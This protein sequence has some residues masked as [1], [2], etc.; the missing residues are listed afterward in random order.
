MLSI[1][2]KHFFSLTL[3]TV[4]LAGCAHRQT[5][6]Y[7][8]PSLSSINLIDRNGLTE[9][10]NSPERLE[11]YSLVNFLQPQPYQKVLR[12]YSRDAHGNIPAC[13][14]SYHV[15]GYPHKYLEVMNSRACGEYK[16]WFANGV[17]KIN[18]EVIEGSADIVNGAERSWVFD[19]N[20][21]AWDENGKLEAR[22]I[23]NKG[24]LEG[25]SLY[26]HPNGN[27]W[28]S[29]PYVQNKINGLVQIFESDET[30]LQ[31][32]L[33]QN[34]KKEGKSIRYWDCDRVA[35]EEEYC[36]D[37]LYNGR[38][39]NPCGE[40][41]AEV[42]NGNGIRALFGKEGIAELQ[43]YKNGIVEGEIKQLDRYG[44][45]CCLYHMK[46]DDKHGEEV[47]YYDAVRLQPNLTPKL[48]ITWF[49]GKIQGISKT[50]YDN[51]VQESQREIS[52]NKKNGHSTAW[53]QDGSLMLIEEYEQ[54][55]LIRGEYFPKGEKF[56]I[57]TVD[58]G[59]GTATL[60]NSN[61]NFIHKVE[62]KN[63]RPIIEE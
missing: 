14:T 34:G 48:S 55:R 50:W 47:F 25:N 37:Y 32:Y 39:Y 45:V 2:S 41:I 7:L 30:L 8:E 26:Y 17:L 62:Y 35:A 52:N 22:I 21:E 56:P 27:I 63:G 5:I 61:G 12:I 28:K 53:Y 11:Q 3:L 1:I 31:S 24:V 18:A 57:S 9:T 44:R 16:E 58:D 40:C 51:G 60:Y 54:D 38:Y 23:Y 33:Y 42:L 29:I 46:N 36:E 13:I 43:T 10:I 4:S 49:E 19:G 6:C 20:C 15:N 59:K